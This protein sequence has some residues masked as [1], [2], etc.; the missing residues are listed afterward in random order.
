MISLGRKKNTS[1]TAADIEEVKIEPSFT[2]EQIIKSK[3]LQDFKDIL[4]VVLKEEEVYTI[5][6]ATKKIEKFKERIVR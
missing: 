5:D 4:N 1:A 6:E 3:K 2:K